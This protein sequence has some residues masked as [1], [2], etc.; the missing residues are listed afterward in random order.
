LILIW[1][2]LM[3]LPFSDFA[4]GP[5]LSQA[6]TEAD[7]P[8]NIKRAPRR[9]AILLIGLGSV[10]AAASAIGL[11]LTPNKPET[12]VAET[13]SPTITRPVMTVTIADQPLVQRQIIE[14]PT[15]EI[16]PTATITPLPEPS[17]STLEPTNTDQPVDDSQPTPQGTPIAFT[18]E[19]RNALSW[20]CYY[21]VGGMGSVKYDA[22]LSVISTV[23]ARYVFNSG[24]GT[25]VLSVLTRP[26]QF[27]IPVITDHGSD[28]FLA[29]VDQYAS[30]ARGS[31]NAY[32]FFD[33]VPGGPSACIIYGFNSFIEF[34]N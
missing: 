19:E 24:M 2:T 27:N 28:A 22:C 3:R 1:A 14:P 25:D 7:Q 30:G 13:S 8:T 9:W 32:L 15:R 6:M 20:M 23:R 5:L 21:E 31:C 12:A 29:T 26:N 33:S 17:I 10:L 18:T 11:F 16:P 34:H 4:D